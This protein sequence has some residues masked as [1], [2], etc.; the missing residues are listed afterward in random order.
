M[1][2]RSYTEQ[3]RIGRVEDYKNIGEDVEAHW[4]PV[5][6]TKRAI[7]AHELSEKAITEVDVMVGEHDGGECA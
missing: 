4:W 5:T 1:T 2:Q 3:W 7:E 6:E